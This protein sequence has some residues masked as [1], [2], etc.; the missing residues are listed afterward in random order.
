M[1]RS[2]CKLLSLRRYSALAKQ[3]MAEF[4]IDAIRNTKHTAR[5]VAELVQSSCGCAD[6]D[7]NADRSVVHPGTGT[8]FR[9][10]SG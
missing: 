5:S 2:A 4:L 1:I 9:S 8:Q 3:P 6:A 7:G 10:S